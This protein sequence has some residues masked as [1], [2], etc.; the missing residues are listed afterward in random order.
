MIYNPYYF[1]NYMMNIPNTIPPINTIRGIS[2]ISRLGQGNN[3]G[4]LSRLSNSL[5]F[6][7]NINWGNL[8]NNTSRTLGVINQ[9]IPL[10][11]QATPMV[12]N[13]KSII[14]LAS[15]F[16]DETDSTNKINNNSNKKNSTKNNTV[17]DNYIKQ[18]ST[19]NSYYDHNQPTFFIN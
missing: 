14:K 7:R 8:I 9:T 11:K 6:I 4:L 12:R 15:V 2:N 3:I 5:G 16:K 17:S 1:P 18:E 13:M 19:N 10:V